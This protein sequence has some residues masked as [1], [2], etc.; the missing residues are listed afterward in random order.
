MLIPALNL[1]FQRLV[2]ARLDYLRTKSILATAISLLALAV[3]FSLQYFVHTIWVNDQYTG[4]MDLQ[5]GE[6]SGAGWWHLFFSSIETALI[7]LYVMLWFKM[8]RPDHPTFL[9]ALSGW[10]IL[11]AYTFLGILD[12]SIQS[13]TVFQYLSLVQLLWVQWSVLLKIFAAL[14]IFYSATRLAKTFQ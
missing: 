9:L 1:Y 6:L 2:A 12:L 7:I 4:F 13:A 8:P 14:L 11:V 3:G 10:R 5:L